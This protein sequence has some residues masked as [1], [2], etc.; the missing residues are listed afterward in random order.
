MDKSKECLPGIDC[1]VTTCAYNS[2]QKCTA[3][4]ILISSKSDDFF[5]FADCIT[6]KPNSFE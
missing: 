6:Y 3:D 1:T 4:R 2:S 5:E